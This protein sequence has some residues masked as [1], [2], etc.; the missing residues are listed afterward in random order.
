MVKGNSIAAQGLLTQQ[1]RVFEGY[2]KGVSG[3]I[4]RGYPLWGLFSERKDAEVR[5]RTNRL[6]CQSSIIVASG[7]RP[8]FE[9]GETRDIR[10][11]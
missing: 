1:R 9:I 11:T 3:A 10:T 7:A 6:V 4:S 2:S 5:P 8:R